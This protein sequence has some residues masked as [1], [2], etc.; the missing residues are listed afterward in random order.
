MLPQLPYLVSSHSYASSP[1]G[2]STEIKQVGILGQ[3]KRHSD[4]NSACMKTT[5]AP[6]PIPTMPELP[7]SQAAGNIGREGPAVGKLT[8][9]EFLGT[10]YPPCARHHQHNAAHDHRTY[11][12][13]KIPHLGAI[14]PIPEAIPASDAC[15]EFS[16]WGQV[17]AVSSPMSWRM[18]TSCP[19]SA[20]PTT[21]TMFQRHSMATPAAAGSPPL[22]DTS[23]AA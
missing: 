4:V 3:A 1:A 9:Q 19:P 8:A 17:T 20:L 11:G 13:A 15:G 16:S 2:I 22:Q 23:Q 6:G 5:R 10:L 7:D 18:A 14:N 21:P 12:N